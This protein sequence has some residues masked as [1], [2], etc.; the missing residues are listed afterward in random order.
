MPH[1]STGAWSQYTVRN[2][3]TEAVS[4]VDLAAV[5]WM[6]AGREMRKV[7]KL[8][9]RP[10]AIGTPMWGE[11]QIGFP[12]SGLPTENIDVLSDAS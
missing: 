10:A 2:C 3:W 8:Q 5:K 11:V 6:A 9:L 4:G 7:A 12:E 1:F